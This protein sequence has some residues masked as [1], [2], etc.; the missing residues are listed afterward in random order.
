MK[1]DTSVGASGPHDFAVRNVALFVSSAIR[2]HRIPDLLRDDRETPLCVG[3]DGENEEVICVKREP[4]YFCEGGWTCNSLFSFRHS[5]DVQLH[6]WES[7][8]LP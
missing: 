7:N 1:L 2:V 8:S 6:I 4:E 3:R 5:P